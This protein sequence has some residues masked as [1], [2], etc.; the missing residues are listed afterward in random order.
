MDR[1]L[2]RRGMSPVTLAACQLLAA[3]VMLAIALAVSVPG[4]RTSLPSA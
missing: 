1:F 3:A 2:A 4:R